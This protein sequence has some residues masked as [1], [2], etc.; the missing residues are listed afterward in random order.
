MNTFNNK[1]V[2]NNNII[3]NNNKVANVDR[4]ANVNS[5]AT[6]KSLSSQI[7]SIVS[8]PK[9]LWQTLIHIVKANLRKEQASLAPYIPST[10]DTPAE[11]LILFRVG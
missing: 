11:S 8:L 10:I 2:S 3:S 4:V 9:N 6:H 7:M 1:K 5:V